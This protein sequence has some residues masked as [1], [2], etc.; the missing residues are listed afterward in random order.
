M[1]FVTTP[2]SNLVGNNTI[3]NKQ[4]GWRCLGL[5]EYCTIRGDSALCRFAASTKI[6]TDAQKVTAV[7]V[8]G[9]VV[10]SRA[11]EDVER[12]AKLWEINISSGVVLCK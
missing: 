9:W 11:L 3:L 12:I 1:N 2:W 7:C 6:W 8:P 5:E 10:K 4:V